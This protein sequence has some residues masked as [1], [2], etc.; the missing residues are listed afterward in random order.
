MEIS[1]KV[2]AAIIA[3]V[4]SLTVALVSY[5]TNKRT[6]SQQREQSERELQRRFTQKLYDLRLESYPE[7]FK[8]T[9]KL[10]GEFLFKR[11]V[12]K[13]QVLEVRSKLLDWNRSRAGFL[14]SQESIKAFY[15]IRNA[16]A[17]Q[18]ED[19]DRTYSKSQLERIWKAKNR[20]RTSLRADVNL[21]YQEESEPDKLPGSR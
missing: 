17:V 8:I 2:M 13:D 20:F 6:L 5:L 11:R 4:V 9:D 12:A 21:L 3:A 16:L 7:A 14:L 15:E 18:P 1:E 19:G 10:T